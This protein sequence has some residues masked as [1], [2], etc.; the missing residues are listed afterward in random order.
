MKKPRLVFPDAQQIW[1]PSSFSSIFEPP[2]FTLFVTKIRTILH[3]IL[4]EIQNFDE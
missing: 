4:S 3:F 2:I 1:P